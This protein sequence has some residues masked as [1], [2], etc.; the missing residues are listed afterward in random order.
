MLKTGDIFCCLKLWEHFLSTLM[1]RKFK[2]TV[3]GFLSL[4]FHFY[5]EFN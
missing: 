1:N 3:Y 2:I 4:Y 5:I